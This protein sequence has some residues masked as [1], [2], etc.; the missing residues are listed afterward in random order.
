MCLSFT[1]WLPKVSH[2]VQDPLPILN[3]SR[4][5]VVY[6]RPPGTYTD[7]NIARRTGTRLKR[8]Y[9]ATSESSFV[10]LSTRIA[11]SLYA[12]LAKEAEVMFVV[13]TAHADLNAVAP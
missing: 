11:V 9:C 2:Q 8:R 10:I 7:I 4:Q 6:S 12:A 5:R 13:L 1:Q 3:A